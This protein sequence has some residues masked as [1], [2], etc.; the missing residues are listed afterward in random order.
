[1]GFARI[2]THVHFVVPTLLAGIEKAGGDPSGKRFS[3]PQM[4]GAD[5][6]MF[7]GWKAP[8]WSPETHLELMDKWQ[9]Q[10]SVL[11]ITS[12]GPAVLGIGKES[13]ALARKLNEEAAELTKKYPGRFEF[14]SS[15]GDFCDV[16]GT[17]AE[18]E[19]GLKL[20]ASGVVVMTS[21]S[22]K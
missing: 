12:P 17:I 13:N 1:M 10:T 9:I 19:Y 22:N 8:D 11:S 15:V 7:T 5:S 2:D 3:T 4:D 20:G 14:F 16:E 21:Y 18:I 6:F